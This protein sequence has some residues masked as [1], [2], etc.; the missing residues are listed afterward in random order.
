[1]GMG[2]EACQHVVSFLVGAA[3]PTALLV[4]LASDR[5]GDGL[6]TISSSW[7][8][9]AG[10]QRPPMAGS[11][12]LAH[13][14]GNTTSAGGRAPTPTTA[15]GHGQEPEFADLAELLPKVATEDRTVIITSVNEA[16]A[17]PNSLLDLFRESFRAGDGIEH[18][19]DH[20]LVVA[21]DDMAFAHC[22]AVHPHCYLLEF[23]S[24]N[25]SSDNKF[26]SEAYVELVWT[27]L[28][29]Q[30]RDVDIV[31]LRNPFWHISV[32][33]DMTT[34]SDVFHGDANSLDN[35][36][37]T[38]FYYVRATNLTVEMLRRWRAARARFPPNH[39]QAIFNEIKHELA[40]DELGVRIQF[41][42]TAR[43]AGFC[44]IYHSDIAAACTMHANCCFGLGNKLYD[45][46][47]VLGQW[48]NYTGLTPQEKTSRKFLWKDPTK[49]GSP[50]KKNWSM[51]P[52]AGM[53]TSKAGPSLSPVVVFLLG[54]ASATTLL[55]FFLTAR[56][57]WPAATAS[58]SVRCST[59]PRANST[60]RAERHAGVASPPPAN[61][62]AD[63]ANAGEAE[64]EQM[65]RRAAMEDRTVIMTSVNEAWA[66]P[67]SL[68]DSFLESFTVGENVSH[69][70]KHIV[71]VAMD[72]RAFRRCR[73]VH[74]H[75]HLLR[76]EKQGLDLSG[77]KSYMTKDYLDLVWS[78]LRLQQR[79]LELGY[80]LLFT[81]VDLAWF[82]NPMVHITAAADITTSSDFY[83]GDPD[84]LGNFPNTGFIYFK[85]TARNARAMAYWHAA[86]RRFP[87]NHDQ[88]VFNE[89]K[90]ELAGELGVRIRFIDAATV[91]G[92]CQLGRD[93]NRIAT[94]HMTCCIGLENKL[95]DLKRVIL[96]WKRYMAHPLWERK[97]G[98]IGWTFE[99]G[100]CIH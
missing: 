1:M 13:Q 69:F 66:A 19:L 65:L 38:G 91:S 39:E 37:N 55:L 24:M 96:D 87:E 53:A 98:K 86:R 11:P 23:K 49:C 10:I 22:K 16:F 58:A 40:G 2:K 72:E 30:Q 90:R 75:C 67:G 41:L 6:S 36:P 79:I 29:L 85:A 97:M 7:G 95:F 33:A 92:F 28:S 42:D 26:M 56:P 52:P 50:D 51:N 17:R 61:N 45:L 57:A 46:R 4:L 48:R 68:L 27:K 60:A 62:E 44:Q 80:N 64:F 9:T 82:R 89:I 88:F 71:V 54:A 70:V 14:E 94:V 99:G 8:S 18:L 15:H 43:F 35:L 47:E 81:D 100:R 3:L 59:V 63:A 34:S 73:A 32:F 84:D 25:L 93:L 78:K 76:P 20:V 31:W 77:A 83:F 74:P 12:P 5:L 21:V